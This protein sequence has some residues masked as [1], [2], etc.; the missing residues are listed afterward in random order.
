MLPPL[1]PTMSLCCFT[2]LIGGRIGLLV[3][4]SPTM[5]LR[6]RL[7][8]IFGRRGLFVTPSPTMASRLCLSP[9]GGGGYPPPAPSLAMTSRLRPSPSLASSSTMSPCLRLLPF[10]GGGDPS[11]ALSLMMVLYLR[12]PT[13]RREKSSSFSSMMATF[14]R[15]LP[16]MM[17]GTESTAEVAVSKLTAVGAATQ[18]GP[19]PSRTLWDMT[20]GGRRA[21]LCYLCSTGVNL[22]DF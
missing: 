20:Q 9:I 6:L 3:M 19:V 22:V 18:G 10:G 14:L 17:K 11:S 13:K 8:P 1:T 12:T 15:P 2:L 7:S 5:T 4:P 16:T 21:A